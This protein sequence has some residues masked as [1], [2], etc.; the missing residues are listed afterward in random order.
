MEF[1]FKEDKIVFNRELSI[2]D[3]ITLKFIKVLDKEHIDYVVISGYIAILFG[4]SR[5]T[6]DVDLF[7]EEMPF[8]KFEKFWNAL[9]KEG[10]ECINV[11]N[12]REA[13]DE[14]LKNKTSIR[15]AEKGDWLPNFEIK[16]PTEE[17]GKYSLKN[18]VKVILNGS[19]LNTS[20]LETQIAYKLFLG[21]EKDIEDAAHLWDIFKDKIDRA[22]FNRFAA[23]LKVENKIKELE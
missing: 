17:L 22:L 1:E 10:F 13:Y 6:E 14:F 15:F 2:L 12:P 18:K 21:S 23:K 20:R 7:V 3:T 19:K 9:S 5:S 8:A 16:F 11:F 4:R